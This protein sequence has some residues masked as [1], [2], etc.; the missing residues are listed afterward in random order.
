MG[1]IA[2]LAL[3]CLFALVGLVVVPEVS[4]QMLLGAY[5]IVLMFVCAAL[6]SSARA[7]LVLAALTILSET[8]T[9]VAYFVY[10]YGAHISL[11]P[12]AVGFILFVG[13]IPLFPLTGAFGGYLG[14][15]Y[16]GETSKRR[17]G[18]KEQRRP[19]GRTAV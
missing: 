9:E 10:V 19:R 6:V 8:L 15:E 7:G 4:D 13:R 12:Y 11:V 3:G 17:T 16:F 1:W 5:A 14:Q 2:G 18:E